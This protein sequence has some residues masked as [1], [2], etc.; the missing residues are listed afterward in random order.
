MGFSLIILF[1]YLFSAALG[2]RC[3]TGFS[4]LAV[5]GGYSLVAMLSLLIAVASL[6]AGVLGCLG[7]SSCCSWALEHGLKSYGTVA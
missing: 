4:P 6:V 3:C 7:F 2:L 5:S 1:I